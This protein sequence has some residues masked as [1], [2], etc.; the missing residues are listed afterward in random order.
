MHRNLLALALLPMLA[1]FPNTRAQEDSVTPSDTDSAAD[2]D[3]DSDTDADSDADSNKDSDPDSAPNAAPSAPTVH[4]TPTAPT[5]AETLTCVIDTDSV[6]PDGDAVTYRYAWSSDSGGARVGATLGAD[7]TTTG[8][9]WTCSVTPSDGTLSGPAGTAS[10]TIGTSFIDYT[11]AYGGT[12][13]AITA[14]TFSMGYGDGY[15]PVHTVTLTRDFWIGQTEVTQEQYRAA[16]GSNPSRYS[17][18]GG[19]CPVETVS[20][21]EAAMYANA[22]SAAEGLEQCYTSTGSE[23]AASLGGD[24]YACEGYRLPTEAEWEYAARGGEAYTYSGSDIVSD[25]AWYNSSSTHPVA[26]KAPNAFGLYD[27]SGNVWEWT[28][29]W[30]YDYYTSGAAADPVGPSS[31]ESRVRR[32]GGAFETAYYSTVYI[33]TSNAPEFQYYAIGIRLTRTRS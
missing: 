24:P 25:V 27:M 17:S 3:T 14:G 7:Y 20:W 1:C 15:G 9:V 32:G 22:L 19:T 21:F 30:W 10:V 31:G 29:D 4:I 28:E 11:T 16:T 12:M 13:V 6:D 33:R 8:A 5:D 2:S 26:G 18:C 23:L